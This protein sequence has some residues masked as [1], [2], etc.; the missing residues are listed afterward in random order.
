MYQFQKKLSQ[1]QLATQSKINPAYLSNMING[2]YTV[3]SGEKEVAIQDKYFV[4]LA[5]A[6]GYQI[7]KNYWY[8]VGT[9]QF[10][11]IITI[12][13]D[14]KKSK[15]SGMVI[16]DTGCGKS[17]AV[18]RFCLKNPKHTYRVTV[19]KMHTLPFILEQLLTLFGIQEKGRCANKMERIINHLKRLRQEGHNVI[20][21]IDEAEN[22]RTPV[23]GMVKA[24]YDGIVNYAAIILIGTTELT[25]KMERMKMANRD[26][27]PQFCRRFKAGTRYLQDVDRSF[28]LFFEKMGVHDKGLQALL[29]QMCDNYGELHDYLMPALRAADER[30]EPL[31]E[32]LFRI[33]NNLPKRA[34]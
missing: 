28:S 27:M 31:T 30:G 1:A 16:G 33:I 13:E 3:Q 9:S 21:V 4:M 2:K 7:Q 29:R 17:Y 22:L 6:I 14:S 12:L 8:S 11:E 10:Q 34:A 20:V 19:S 24:L 25:D 26:G 15:M 32:G 23:F 5:E 18:D